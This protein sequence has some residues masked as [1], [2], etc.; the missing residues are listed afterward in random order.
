MSRVLTETLFRYAWD[1]YSKGLRGD[2]LRSTIKQYAINNKYSDIYRNPMHCVA[3]MVRWGTKLTKTDALKC[4]LLA[5]EMSFQ[6]LNHHAIRW[7]AFKAGLTKSENEGVNLMMVKK[8]HQY[9]NSAEK[10]TIQLPTEIV[11][12][13]SPPKNTKKAPVG[14]MDME[15][16]K[17]ED[18]HQ[19]KNRQKLVNILKNL[20]LDMRNK[21]EELKREGQKELRKTEFIWHRLLVSFS[22]MGN[23]RGYRGLILNKDN[24]NKVTF[25]SL[26]RLSSN[27]RLK[28]LEDIFSVAGLRMPIPKAHWQARNYEK[29]I[30]LGGL[31]KVNKEAL[32]QPGT[33]AKIDYMKQFDGIGDKYA[34]NIWMDVHHP[35]FYENIAIDER[36]KSISLALG[37]SFRAYADHEKFYLDIAHEANL[38]GWELDRLLYNFKDYFLLNLH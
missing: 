17:K 25:D 16:T 22:T 21:L 5:I 20:P 8:A 19:A 12:Q 29:I 3:D 24:Y 6:G 7:S 13:G 1:R 30:N 23:S 32:G 37:Y 34:R 18:H 26:S 4:L 31:S 27:Q 28:R 33:K 9:L 38:Q 36:I 15:E 2:I 35:D 11:S 10:D 14:K